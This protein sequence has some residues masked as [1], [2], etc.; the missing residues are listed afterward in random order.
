MVTLAP[1][2]PGDPDDWSNFR[3][4]LRMHFDVVS[5]KSFTHYLVKIISAY[6]YI[7]LKL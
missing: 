1:S 2:E 5:Q 4:L 3:Q 6:T 7:E